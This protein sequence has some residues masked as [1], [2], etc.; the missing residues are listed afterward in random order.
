MVISPMLRGM[1]GLH[2]DAQKH[3][4]T[5]A[6]HA[7]ANWKEFEIREI[8]TGKGAVDLQYSRTVDAITVIANRRGT[9]DMQLEFRPA[10]SLR[11]TVLDATLNGRSVAFQME[12]HGSDQHVIVNGKLNSGAN[13]LKIRL[14]DDFAVTFEGRLPALGGTSQGLRVLSEKWSSSHDTL[15]LQAQGLAGTKHPLSGLAKNQLK[16]RKGR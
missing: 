15:T 7:P 9:E 1:F 8:A 6:P 12:S 2:F 16:S 13:T 5:F 14:R 10:V 4:L 3:E 11:A